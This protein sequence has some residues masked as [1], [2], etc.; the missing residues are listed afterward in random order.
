L[1]IGIV[2]GEVKMM[3]TIIGSSFRQ[4]I[5][6]KIQ[7]EIHAFPCNL[8]LPNS[9]THPVNSKSTDRAICVGSNFFLVSLNQ[10]QSSK[11]VDSKNKKRSKKLK[12]L[13]VPL[14][15]FLNFE[16]KFFVEFLTFD[17]WKYLGGNKNYV[18]RRPIAYFVHLS[19][20]KVE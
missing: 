6:P 19:R 15:L 1:I 10:I 5:A 11:A 3:F 4:Y 2:L 17:S 12:N 7:Y 20:Q 18:Y 14:V 9:S 8:P 16:P 13:G